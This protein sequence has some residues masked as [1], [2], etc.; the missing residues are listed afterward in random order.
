MNDGREHTPL[1][2]AGALP[3]LYHRYDRGHWQAV[4]AAIVAEISLCLHVNGHDLVT[5]QCSPV[6]QEAMAIGFLAAEGFIE[7]L[8]DIELLELSHSGTCV[9]IW[10]RR[11]VTLP[12]RFIK[13]S[14]CGEGVTFDDLS[15]Q[16]APLTHT[17]TVTPA[18]LMALF[19]ELGR[20]ETLYPLTRG[21]HAAALCRPEGIV[22]VAED[23]GR[24]NTLDKLRGKAMLQGITTEGAILITT[25]RISSEM[26]GKAAK[27]GVPIIA[28]RTSPTSRS[29]ALAQ[30]WNITVVGYVRRES[31]RVYT[32]PWRVMAPSEPRQAVEAV[33]TPASPAWADDGI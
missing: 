11:P 15:R 22:L 33:E 8:E 14:G 30:A 1:L 10:L 3:I 12:R 20:R 19:Q 6:D 7:K 18:Q 5:Y 29:V 23:V 24:H 28:S 2:P 26:L 17:T 32:A 31:L 27:M 21:I 16:Q 25:G 9:D 4:S 13:T